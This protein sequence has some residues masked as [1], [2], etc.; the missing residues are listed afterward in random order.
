MKNSVYHFLTNIKHRT[1][2][3][4]LIDP[5]VKNDDKL[6]DIVDKINYANFD[7]VL[8]GGS[9]LSDNKYLD[10]IRKIKEL[11][12]KPLILFPGSSSQINE[13]V[14]AVL[15]L[16]L[17]SGRNPKY[18]IDE[19]VNSALSIYNSNIE[20][21]PVGYILIDG[22][23]ISAVQLESETA[24]IP[25]EKE[26]T[27][28][29]HALAGQYLGHKLIFLEAGS[30][31]NKHIS[32]SLIGK[33]KK[34][35]DIPIIIGG[36]IVNIEIAKDIKKG[37]PDFMVVGNYLEQENNKEEMKDIVSLIHE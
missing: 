12:S 19:H 8:V 11:V 18:L 14:D 4:A 13:H 6:I 3:L 15:Y 7:A 28:I 32:G 9:I 16:S 23:K 31:A 5:D 21:I 37:F 22:S 35:L 2:A 25:F 26:E 27:I 30:G 29:S 17:I 36:G 10:R 1:A 34:Y 20:T 24:P 33:I